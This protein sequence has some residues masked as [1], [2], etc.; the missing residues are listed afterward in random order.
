MMATR[1][2]VVDIFWFSFP[3]KHRGFFSMQNL[4]RGVGKTPEC[5]LAVSLATIVEMFLWKLFKL[6]MG[7][8]QDLCL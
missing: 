4:E 5:C 1:D 6:P 8:R 2:I 7:V 3:D